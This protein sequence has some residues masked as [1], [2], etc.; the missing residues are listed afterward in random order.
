MN[1]TT[2]LS[3]L[4]LLNE[5]HDLEK[6]VD[7][8]AIQRDMDTECIERIRNA[9]YQL[10]VDLEWISSHIN[11]ITSSPQGFRIQLHHTGDWDRYFPTLREAV[12]YHMVNPSKPS[13]RTS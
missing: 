13:D 10:E 7:S 1:D 9:A 4:D 12:E 2:N 6:Q 11:A 3:R 8:L 5:I